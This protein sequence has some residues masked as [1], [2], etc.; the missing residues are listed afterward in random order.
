MSAVMTFLNEARQLTI[1]P[2][3]YCQVAHSRY[4][5]EKSLFRDCLTLQHKMHYIS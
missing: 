5:L 1:G 3:G 4:V 2:L